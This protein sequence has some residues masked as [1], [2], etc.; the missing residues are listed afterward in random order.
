MLSQVMGSIVLSGK[1]N[2]EV[3]VV[4][5]CKDAF[6]TSTEQGK[7]EFCCNGILLLLITEHVSTIVPLFQALFD[8]K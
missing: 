4:Q 6:V 5:E 1:N 3:M 8:I 2:A 7:R